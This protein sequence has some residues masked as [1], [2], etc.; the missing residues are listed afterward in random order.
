MSGENGR[1]KL[2]DIK[3]K[4]E[5]KIREERM[6]EDIKE[7]SSERLTRECILVVGTTG[8]KKYISDPKT[9]FLLIPS[10]ST[11]R[12]FIPSESTNPLINPF[13]KH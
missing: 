1:K 10:E 3:T 8:D 2:E 12:W 7:K 13:R 9:F 6:K 5:N 4:E 11:N